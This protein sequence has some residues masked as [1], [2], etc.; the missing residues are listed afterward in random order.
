MTTP[1]K[2]KPKKQKAKP[3]AVEFVKLFAYGTLQLGCKLHGWLS[4]SR[5]A[6]KVQD[7]VIIGYS[8]ID[9]GP[10]PGLVKVGTEGHRVM[11]EVWSVH[12][13]LFRDL[14]EMEERVG[15]TTVDV[16]TRNNGEAKAFLYATLEEGTVRWSPDRSNLKSSKSEL[17]KKV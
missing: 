16:R 12:P 1:S 4:D 11:G 8:L 2:K 9:F 6:L 14:K 10:Y 13:L 7:D 15:Y 3:E 5:Y 17:I